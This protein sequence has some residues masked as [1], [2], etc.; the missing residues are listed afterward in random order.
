MAEI[1]LTRA[2]QQLDDDGF[3]EMIVKANALFEAERI[4]KY[5]SYKEDKEINTAILEAEVKFV[6]RVFGPSG[7]ERFKEMTDR[8]ILNRKKLEEVRSKVTNEYFPTLA[9]FPDW[10]SEDEEKRCHEIESMYKQ[11]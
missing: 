9:K 11:I 5:G 1:Y 8:R 7:V 6:D 10:N 3:C 4:Y 2:S